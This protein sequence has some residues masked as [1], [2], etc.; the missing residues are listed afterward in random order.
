MVA[1]YEYEYEAWRFNVALADYL[2]LGMQSIKEVSRTAT[3]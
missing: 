1:E 2:Y 3:F